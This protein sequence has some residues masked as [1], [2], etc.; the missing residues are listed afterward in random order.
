MGSA[1]NGFVGK[2]PAHVSDLC[3]SDGFPT[4]IA[5]DRLVG[6]G[7]GLDNDIVGNGPVK[8]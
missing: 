3:L 2:R 5:L 6:W 4:T 8:Y 7:T 1:V